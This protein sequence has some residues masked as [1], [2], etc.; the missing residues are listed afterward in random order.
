M[1]RIRQS[2]IK[3]AANLIMKNYPDKIT[4]DFESNK[5]FLNE[6]VEIYSKKLRNRLAGYLVNLKKQAGKII[7]PP[8]KGKKIRSKKDRVKR[9][10][11]KWV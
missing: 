10:R 3:D 6:N 11:R 7:N 2:S 5:Q 9:Q 4:T 1:G 8:R